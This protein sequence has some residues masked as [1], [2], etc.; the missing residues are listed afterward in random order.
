MASREYR[1]N[2]ASPSTLVNITYLWAQ[3]HWCYLAAVLDLYTRRVVGWALSEH[4]DTDL[5]IKALDMAF[6][7]RGRPQ[8]VMFH[9]DQ[10][11][12]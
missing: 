4:P 8:G 3:G 10:G 5:V 9:S 6:E 1:V 11:S 12:Q 7:Q 2:P